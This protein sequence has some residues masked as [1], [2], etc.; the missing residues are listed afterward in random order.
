MN[1]AKFMISSV[2]FIVLTAIKLSMPS[3]A[4]SIS[5]EIRSVLITEEAQ[6]QSVMELGASLTDGRL[7]SAFENDMS[8]SEIIPVLEVLDYQNVLPLPESEPEPAEEE[9]TP[10]KVQAFI[11]S[12]AAY[13]EYAVPENVSYEMPELPFEYISPVSGASSSGFGYRMHP[14]HNE[15]RYHYGTDFAANSGDNVCAFADGTIRETG[16]NDSYG[17]YMIIDHGDG[18]SSLYAHCSQMCLS[19]GEVSKGDV[20]ALVGASGAVTGPHLHFEL[21]HDDVY[22]NPEYYV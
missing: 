21:M 4:D 16:E 9:E 2:I 20:I 6:T 3:L 13:S 7:F 10:A 19:S 12:Q 15:V 18:Y 11:E 17:K 14:I 22:L 5:H 8:D 1:Y